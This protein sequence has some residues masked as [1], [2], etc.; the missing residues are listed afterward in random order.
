MSD[1]YS[2]VLNV[3][4]LT[5]GLIGVLILFRWGM[6]FRVSFGGAH[7]I[8][9]E[10]DHATAALDCVYSVCGWL[11]LTFLLL[12]WACQIVAVLMP[13]SRLSE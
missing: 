9:D 10:G 6:P 5:L 2:K 8:T 13:S 11:G 4:G 12:G 3:I 7:A 1:D